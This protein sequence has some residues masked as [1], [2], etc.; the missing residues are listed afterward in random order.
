ME[1]KLRRAISRYV[2]ARLDDSWKGGGDPDD[3]PRIEAALK[4]AA[5]QLDT[6]I[7]QVFPEEV[8]YVG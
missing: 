1:K 3:I 5:K 8:P 4:A 7:R 6:V 2:N